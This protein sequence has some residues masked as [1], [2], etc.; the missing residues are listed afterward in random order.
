[1]KFVKQQSKLSVTNIDNLI[2]KKAKRNKERRKHSKLLPNSIRALFVGPSDCGKTNCLF[3]LLLDINGLKFKN[4]YIYSKSLYQPKYEYLTKIMA[5]IPEIGYHLFSNNCD[6]IPVEQAKRNSIFIFDDVACEKQDNIRSYF[7]MG[8][9][10]DIDSFYLC[11]TYSRIPKQLIR[12]N[13]NFLCIFKQDNRN[14]KYIYNEH[15]NC[16]LTYD[17]FYKAC[18][19][20]WKE[21][22]GFLVIDK[23]SGLH[24]GRYRKGFDNFISFSVDNT[25]TKKK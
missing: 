23:T 12:D 17:Q 11:Q 25:E 16:D 5:S 15:V 20:C 9:H 8:R 21:K 3:T 6:V 7:A 13:S 18:V 10:S 24:T 1:M 19:E 22:Y 14:L 4:I 2:I